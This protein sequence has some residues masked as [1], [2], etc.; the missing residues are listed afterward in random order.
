MARA[1]GNDTRL[2]ETLRQNFTLVWRAMRR[3]G[4]AEHTVDD[5]TQEVFII[6][7]RKLDTVEPGCERPYLYGI[8][9]RVA[10]NCRRARRN[11]R[12][13]YDD[14]LVSNTAQ[15]GPTT[16]R[17][18]EEKQMREMLD[19]ILDGLPEDLRTAFVLF[20]FEGFSE[21][22][23]AELCC[24][25]LGTAASRIRRARDQFRDAARRLKR[26]RSL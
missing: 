22:E 9:L 11:Q 19:G 3:L 21:R 7:A 26:R 8:A 10:A 25:P 13:S 4:V 16:D 2:V 20:E 12:E 14:E 15:E 17:L 6:A 24:V 5:A 23:I 18:L 1:R